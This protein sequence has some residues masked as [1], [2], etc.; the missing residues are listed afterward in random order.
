MTLRSPEVRTMRRVGPS[1]V[2]ATTS[3]ALPP[4]STK[5]GVT[6]LMAAFPF[7]FHRRLR[8]RPR[9]RPPRRRQKAD[10]IVR[11]QPIGCLRRTC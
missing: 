4:I 3:M 6:P 11:P 9:P 2:S 7:G 8:F 5:L 1:A 10:W